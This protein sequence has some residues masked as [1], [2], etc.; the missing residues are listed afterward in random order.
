MSLTDGRTNEIRPPKF[1][2]RIDS[3]PVHSDH[4]RIGHPSREQDHLGLLIDDEVGE[5][6][7]E[8]QNES[9]PECI[10]AYSFTAS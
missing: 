9:T 2:G 10:W 3:T 6:P 4:P 1:G 8:P 5:R 7:I